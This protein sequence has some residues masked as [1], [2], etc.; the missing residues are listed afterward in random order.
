MFIELRRSR[1]GCKI[2]PYYAGGHGYADDLL[3]LSPSRSGLQEMVD[4]ASKYA[5]EHKIEFSTDPKPEKSKTKG[6]VFSRT[7]LNFTQTTILLYGNA[8][9]WVS[10]SKYL[11]GKLTAS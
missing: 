6:M 4:I 10:E 5:K 8:L 9:P 3:L 2:G 11:W 7:P 1:S